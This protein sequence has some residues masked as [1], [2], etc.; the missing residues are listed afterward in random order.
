MT[1]LVDTGGLILLLD[2]DAGDHAAAVEGAQAAQRLVLSPFVL[3]EADYLVSRRLG[4]DIA[5]AM[6][7]DVAAGAYELAAIAPSDIAAAVAVQQKFDDLRIGLTDASL[8]VLAERYGT[9]DL[10]TTDLRHFRALRWRG[11]SEFRLL[12]SDA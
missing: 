12:P 2:A 7:H 3:A 11:R 8:V 6:Q 1:L 10:L 5:L 4:A 9:G